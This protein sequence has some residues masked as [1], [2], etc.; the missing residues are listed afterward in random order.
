MSMT[1]C[2][3]L[4]IWAAFVCVTWTVTAV[5]AGPPSVR[6]LADATPIAAS[7]SYKRK[8]TNYRCGVISEKDQPIF[9]CPICGA[10]TVPF[11]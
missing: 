5:I 3:Q 4:V 1:I 2:R 9:K 11:K 6:S 10:S 7:K 8:C